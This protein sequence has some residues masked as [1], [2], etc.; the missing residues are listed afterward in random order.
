MMEFK[1]NDRALLEGN[2][3]G[4]VKVLCKEGT[5]TILAATIVHP[6]A[7]DLISEL[8]LCITNK[9]GLG[10]LAPVIHPYPTQADAIRRVGDFYNRSRLTTVAKI[11]LRKLA[12]R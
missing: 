1:N 12:N 11:F 6:N 7:G 9:I 2:T 3:E 8:T 5:D 4:F 10:L